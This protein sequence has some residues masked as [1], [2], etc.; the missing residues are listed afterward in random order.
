MIQNWKIGKQSMFLFHVLITEAE[1][2]KE[3]NGIFGLLFFDISHLSLIQLFQFTE[4]Y[5]YITC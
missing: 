5:C 3:P 4:F 1:E 2:I